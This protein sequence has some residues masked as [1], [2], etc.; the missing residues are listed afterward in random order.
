MKLRLLKL[1]EDDLK[2]RKF[3]KDLTEGEKDEEDIL[4]YQNLLYIFE[5][6]Y[7]K[8]ITYHHNDLLAGHFK[9][10]ETRKLFARKYFTSIFHQNVE[11]YEKDCNVYL[12]SKVVCHKLYKDL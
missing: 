10:K 9:I 1:P 11:A 7:S 3:K 4:H 8:L 12:A 5:N 6:I 2:T